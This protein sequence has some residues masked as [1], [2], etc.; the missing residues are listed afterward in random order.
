MTPADSDRHDA[1]LARYLATREPHVIGRGREVTARRKD[2]SVFPALLS[3][4]EVAGAEPPRFVGFVHDV[5]VRRPPEEEGRRIPERPGHAARLPPAAETSRGSAPEQRP[6]P[7]GA[8][9]VRPG[10]TAHGGGAIAVWDGGRGVSPAVVPHLFEPFCTSKTA[11]T[12]L[13]LAISRTIAARHGGTL[14]YE[15]NAPSGACFTLRLPLK[16]GDPA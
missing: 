9:G 1:H 16:T 5:T 10:L 15:A 11:G 4:G 12:G 13:G 14:E 7:S 2:G 3:V 6:R 8:V